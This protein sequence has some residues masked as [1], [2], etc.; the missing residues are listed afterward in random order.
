MCL[1]RFEAAV[2]DLAG[3]ERVVAN[4]DECALTVE[5]VP[6][7]TDEAALH[8]LLVPDGVAARADAST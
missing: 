2:G 5:Y 3:V 4:P 7:R 6:S 1:E 8:E